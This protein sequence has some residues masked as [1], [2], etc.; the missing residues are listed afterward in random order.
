MTEDLQKIKVLVL[1]VDGVLTDGTL[2]VHADGSESKM[3]NSLDGHGLRMWMRTGK[4]AALLSGRESEAVTCWAKRLGFTAAFG[5]CKKKLP[6]LKNFVEE[7]SLLPENIAYVGDDVVDLPRMRYSGFSAAPVNAVDEVK[8]E[9]D[10]VTS[11]GGGY[12]A[13]REVVEHV[14]RQTGDWNEQMKRYL[15]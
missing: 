11:R 12:G 6:V 3:L 7:L 2:V 8:N 1:D 9:A 4:K 14:L 10:F 5:G 15:S 13:V